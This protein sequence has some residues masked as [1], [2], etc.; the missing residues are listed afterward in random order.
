MKFIKIP[1]NK[2]WPSHPWLIIHGYTIVANEASKRKLNINTINSCLINP[3]SYKILFF[4][5]ILVNIFNITDINSLITNRKILDLF[6]HS[7][8]FYVI[9]SIFFQIFLKHNGCDFIS[10][11]FTSNWWMLTQLVYKKDYWLHCSAD[12]NKYSF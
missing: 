4:H 6:I 10:E 11:S 9:N 8:F 2:S 12:S 5:Q 3:D 1:I 7:S